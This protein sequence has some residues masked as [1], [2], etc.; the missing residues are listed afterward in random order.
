MDKLYKGIYYLIIT[1]FIGVFILFMLFIFVKEPDL[2]TTMLLLA[3]MYIFLIVIGS[4]L[5]LVS[6]KAGRLE[7]VSRGVLFDMVKEI[8]QSAG[9]QGPKINIY[10]RP[11]KKKPIA[12]ASVQGY[13]NYTVIFNEDFIDRLEEN[14]IKAVVYHEAYHIIQKHDLIR[15][16][17]WAAF[18]LLPSV[19]LTMI[20][21]FDIPPKGYSILSVTGLFIYMGAG[22]MTLHFFRRQEIN[23]DIYAVKRMGN[24]QAIIKALTKMTIDNGEKTEV[25]IVRQLL[26]THPYLNKRINYIKR[27]SLH[28]EI[29][30]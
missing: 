28:I 27:S 4:Y 17:I 11:R 5:P 16:I 21:F 19:F 25:N 8:L 20:G 29:K 13:S 12:N 15:T 3:A 14:E 23:A 22:L 26:A 10:I 1:A 7:A 24:T 2:N 18:G 9:I 30:E 6:A